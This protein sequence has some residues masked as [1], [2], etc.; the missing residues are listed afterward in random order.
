MS[1]ERPDNSHVWWVPPDQLDPVE[2]EDLIEQGRLRST[3]PIGSA[4]LRAPRRSYVLAG[5]AVAALLGGGATAFAVTNSGAPSAAVSSAVVAAPA[6]PNAAQGPTGHMGFRH[7]GG[8]FG[9]PHALLHGQFTVAKPGGGYETVDIQN[10]DVT[11]VSNTSITLK[12]SDGFTHSYAIVGSTMVDAQRGG[13]GSVK[14]G[15]QALVLATVSGNTA[16]AANI[17]DITLLQQSRQA[18]GFGQSG[19]GGSGG[20]QPG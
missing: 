17:R 9:G 8:G 14:V 15:N 3:R 13:I 6:A 1:D 19:S 5:V 11:A 7:F 4:S 18:F 20:A 16:T 10:G 12:S 2:R